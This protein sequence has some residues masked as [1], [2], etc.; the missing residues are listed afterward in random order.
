M[1]TCIV[2]GLPVVPREFLSERPRSRNALRPVS[3]SLKRGAGGLVS[4]SES[5]PTRRKARPRG[6]GLSFGVSQI[7][8]AAGPCGRII[9]GK[10]PTQRR[11]TKLV[12]QRAAQKKPRYLAGLR[13]HRVGLPLRQR[14]TH[15]YIPQ[16]V[17]QRAG[18]SRRSSADAGKVPHQTVAET[19]FTPALSSVPQLLFETLNPTPHFGGIVE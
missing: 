18:N 12:A 10:P 17:A 19:S 6:A 5:D 13:F 2:G 8:P 14:Q 9:S 7:G 1:T 3:P 4:M 16:P 11:A 15:R